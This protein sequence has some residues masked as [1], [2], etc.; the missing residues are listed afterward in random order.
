MVLHKVTMNQMVLLIV[1]MNQMASHILT[2]NPLVFHIVIMIHMTLR[3]YENKSSNDAKLHPQELCKGRIVHSI[4]ILSSGDLPMAYSKGVNARRPTFFFNKYFME[5][6]HVVMD[7]ME[8]RLV[9][10]NMLEYK[11]DCSV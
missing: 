7:C 5:W 11:Q 9:E 10:Q 6:D 1:I 4:C 2:L 8:Q 3:D